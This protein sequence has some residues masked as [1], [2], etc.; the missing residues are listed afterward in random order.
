MKPAVDAIR[1]ATELAALAALVVA[2]FA[3]SWPLAIALPAAFAFAWG[4]WVAPRAGTRLADPIR[5]MVEIVLFAAAGGSLAATA[6]VPLGL[7]LTVAAVAAA[8]AT[9]RG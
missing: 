9:R 7:L 3:I 6:S 8:V 4:R 5:L 2:G 1:F